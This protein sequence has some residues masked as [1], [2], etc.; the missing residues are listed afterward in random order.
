MIRK[1]QMIVAVGGLIVAGL[2]GCG[3][4]G[5]KE[6]AG[7]TGQSAVRP[8]DPVA[9]VAHDFLVAVLQ[10]NEP[11][12]VACLTPA[13]V[14]RLQESNKRFPALGAGTTTFQIGEIRKPSDTQ[15]LVQCLLADQGQDGQPTKDELC[16]LM[17]L[18]DSQ[19]RVAGLAFGSSNGQ[20]AIF[21]FENA[22]RPLEAV[23]APPTETPSEATPPVSSRPSPPRTANET[24]PVLNR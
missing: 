20:P 24:P 5:A 18:V 16:C 4:R 14:Q 6:T 17:K 19:W 15:A 2:A 10:G 21:D 13:A 3:Q 11:Q 22:P 9:A 23:V 8:S 12:I 1:L 7:G